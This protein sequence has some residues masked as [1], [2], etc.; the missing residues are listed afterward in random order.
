MVQYTLNLAGYLQINV[1]P[2]IMLPVEM[3]SHQVLQLFELI[4]LKYFVCACVV[5][6]NRL[7]FYDKGPRFT[8][9]W[10]QLRG[11]I[12]KAS[13]IEE[14]NLYLLSKDNF[15]SLRLFQIISLRSQRIFKF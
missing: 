11:Y 12:Q 5:D 10:I 7:P 8:M 14:G 6:D 4:N 3:I 9:T 15:A 13:E 1:S 2:D